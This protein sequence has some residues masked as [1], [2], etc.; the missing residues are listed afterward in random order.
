MRQPLPDFPPLYASAAWW[1]E[2]VASRLGG[3]DARGATVAANRGSGLRN[4]DWMRFTI[5]VDETLS[6]PVA[7][8]ASALKNRYPDSWVLAQEAQRDGRKI[9]SSIATAYGRQPFFHLIKE[10]L[11]APLLG[12]EDRKASQVC[13]EAFQAVERLLGLDGE[14]LIFD[15]RMKIADKDHTLRQVAL[16]SSPKF[17]LSIIDALVR[18][19]PGAIFALLP[20]F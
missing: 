2:Y 8:G 7:G 11:F 20:A 3:I 17:G 4:R 12:L 9:L 15:L 13:L 19:G 10:E 1:K 14:R 18:K 6:L 5:E 16:E